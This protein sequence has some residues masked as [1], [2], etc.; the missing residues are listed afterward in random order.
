MKEGYFIEWNGEGWQSV[1]PS[2]EAS[3]SQLH[4][5]IVDAIYYMV[6]ECD[7]DRRKIFVTTGD[8][9]YFP[10]VSK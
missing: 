3:K 5:D 2:N 9:V 8:G 10:I 6:K 4:T 1:F 7:V